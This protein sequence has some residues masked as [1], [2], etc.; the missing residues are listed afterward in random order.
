MFSST[1]SLKKL[2][3]DDKCTEKDVLTSDI[4]YCI[5]NLLFKAN[6]RTYIFEFV[7]ISQKF[8]IS[9]FACV[10]SYLCNVNCYLY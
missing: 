10:Y 7:F 4:H 6:V 2:E 8:S 3:K 5:D 9:V 1:G